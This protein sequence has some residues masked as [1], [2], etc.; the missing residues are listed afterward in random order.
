MSRHVLLEFMATPMAAPETPALRR[1]RWAWAALCASLCAGV[2]MISFWVAT[3]GHWASAAVFV[4]AVATVWIGW[5][6]FRSKIRADEAWN[7]K[8][9][10]A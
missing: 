6:Y 3:F 7:A 8:E 10:G 5:I 4:L 9:P 1:L 2:G